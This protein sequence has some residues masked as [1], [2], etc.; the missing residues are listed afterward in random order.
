MSGG[1]P[2]LCPHTKMKK[3]F[4]YYNIAPKSP[5]FKVLTY[6]SDQIIRPGQR[7]K[8]PL[9]KK[10]VIGL[11]L[12]KIKGEPE[13]LDTRGENFK[14]KEI[15]GIDFRYPPSRAGANPLA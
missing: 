10:E 1:L 2:G 12:E 8:I 3:Q 15:S 9:G 6:K 11:I 13:R 14:I 7:V 4:Y 5:L